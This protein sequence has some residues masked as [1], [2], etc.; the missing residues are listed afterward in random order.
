MKK[1]LL[2]IN[3]FLITFSTAMAQTYEFRNFSS[4]PWTVTFSLMDGY[5]NHTQ[6]T[7]FVI[8]PNTL[9][10]INYNRRV[11]EE[12]A[13]SGKWLGQVIITDFE[14]KSRCYIVADYSW[15]AGDGVAP[16]IEH[17]GKTGP[18]FLNVSNDTTYDGDMDFIGDSW[19]DDKQNFG[20]TC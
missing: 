5:V 18:V 17:K 19:G 8:Q 12:P 10:P 20:A 9:I 7:S 16:Y 1:I 2:V 11:E 13:S 4:K 15:A 3:M 6:Y 14:N